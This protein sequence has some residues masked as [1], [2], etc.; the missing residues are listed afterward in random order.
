MQSRLFVV[1]LD[2]F[3]DVGAQVI[4][5]A[6]LIGVDFFPSIALRFASMR[7]WLYRSSI[8]LLTCPAIAIIVESD[9]PPSAS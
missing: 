9:V 7:T 8:R 5:V 1:S 2:K 4:E 3:F 6:V